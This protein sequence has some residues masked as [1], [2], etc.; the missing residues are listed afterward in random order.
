MKKNRD[1][2]DRAFGAFFGLMGLMIILQFLFYAG[3]VGVA[4]WLFIK[5]VL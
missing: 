1:E 4:I 2:F 3:L 5:F